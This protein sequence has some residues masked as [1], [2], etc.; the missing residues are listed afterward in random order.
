MWIQTA[1]NKTLISL[2]AFS[3]LFCAIIASQYFR[4]VFSSELMSDATGHYVTTLLAHDYIRNILPANPVTYAVD[5]FIHYPSIRIG[6]NPPLFYAFSSL[7]ALITSDSVQS[8]LIL[9]AVLG[10]LYCVIS[11]WWHTRLQ[12]LSA[13][14]I[15]AVSIALLPTF[16]R[17]AGS[18][19]LDIPIGIFSLIAAICYAKFLHQ[20]DRRPAVIFS[21]FAAAALLVKLSSLFLAVMVP[22]AILISGKYSLLRSRN[23]WLPVLIVGTLVTPW[24][25]FTFETLVSGA[26]TQWDYAYPL[27][28]LTGYLSVLAKNLTLPG[29]A[30]VIAGLIDRLRFIRACKGSFEADHWAVIIALACSVILLQVFIPANILD[31]YMITALGPLM[32]MMWP[33]AAAVGNLLARQLE[34]RKLTSENFNRKIP[35][36]ILTVILGMIFIN[37][38]Q[39]EPAPTNQMALVAKKVF[40]NLPANNPVVVI[41]SDGSRGS[42]FIAQVAQL[43]PVRPSIFTVRGARL[44]GEESGFMNIDYKPKFSTPGEVL[45][46]LQRLSVAM[47]IV[48]RAAEAQI[49]QHN[50]DLAWLVDN[51]P[52]LWHTVWTMDNPGGDGTLSLHILKSSESKV[53]DISLLREAFRPNSGNIGTAQ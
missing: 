20:G 14:I 19:L 30:L 8:A 10:A 46:E 5:Y 51:K 11:M 25:L 41:G 40:D 42:S 22:L 44:F 50:K 7:W 53:K 49:W 6:S 24:Y 29:C 27:L 47:I 1:R 38:L 3:A 23:F 43:D 37:A 26:K 31:R 17:V 15:V 28:A 12:G 4:G 16:Q 2:L 52:E 35:H 32:M 34:R 13:G 9:S 21:I 36:L 33:G 18:F 39:I 48:D 45:N